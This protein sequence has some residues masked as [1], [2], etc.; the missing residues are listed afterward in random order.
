MVAYVAA[1]FCRKAVYLYHLPVLK[2]MVSPG[3][4][5]RYVHYA[6][7]TIA[8]AVKSPEQHIAIAK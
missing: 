1:F 4:Y 6:Q 7:E 2:E 3:W 5:Q 8:A